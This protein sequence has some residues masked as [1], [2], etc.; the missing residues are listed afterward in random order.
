MGGGGSGRWVGVVVGG[1]LVVGLSKDHDYLGSEWGLLR[2]GRWLRM[3]I[4]ERGRLLIITNY[5][6]VNDN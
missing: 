1:G 4:V 2:S 3:R 6:K 5:S